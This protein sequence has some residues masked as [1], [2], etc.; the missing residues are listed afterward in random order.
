[1]YVILGIVS[2]FS[3][4]LLSPL[5]ANGTALVNK[6]VIFHYKMEDTKAIESTLLNPYAQVRKRHAFAVGGSKMAAGMDKIIL[7]GF[8]SEF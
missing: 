6:M 8:M 5:L 7:G 4:H 1:M 2:I 3:L